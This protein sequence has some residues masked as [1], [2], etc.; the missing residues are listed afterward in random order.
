[1]VCNLLSDNVH[2]MKTEVLKHDVLKERLESSEYGSF[3]QKHII[4]QVFISDT[5]Y[6]RYIFTEQKHEQN[7][8]IVLLLIK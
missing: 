7:L 8:F 1:M 5:T 4:Q 2:E 6:N 3:A